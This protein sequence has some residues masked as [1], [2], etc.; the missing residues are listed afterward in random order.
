MNIFFD[1]DYTLL[2]VDGSIRPGTHDIMKR[3]KADG[4]TIYV[5]SG[6]GI[7][8]TEVRRNGLEGFVT[9]CFE[10]PIEHLEAAFKDLPVPVK[11]D[12]VIDDHPGIPAVFGGVWVRPYL[13]AGGID[14]EL[15]RVYDVITAYA[16][17]LSAGTKAAR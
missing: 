12:F 11:P 5:W 8:W 13:G 17:N 10:K 16:R 15:Q 14:N 1:V 9:D 6:V 4:H 2:G 7:R 3:L